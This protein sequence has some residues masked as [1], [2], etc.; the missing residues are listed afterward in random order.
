MYGGSLEN[1]YTVPLLKMVE[2]MENED[3][4]EEHAD[5]EDDVQRCMAVIV[6]IFC[7]DLL[8][9]PFTNFEWRVQD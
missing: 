8:K 1:T 6:G 3:T 9:G 7:L 5:I 2:Y 4:T